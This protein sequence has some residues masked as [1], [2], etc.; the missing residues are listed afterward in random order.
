MKT[1]HQDHRPV[2]ALDLNEEG[3]GQPITNRKYLALG[4]PLPSSQFE[5]FATRRSKPVR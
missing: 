4:L 5:I 2:C 3:L 1:S